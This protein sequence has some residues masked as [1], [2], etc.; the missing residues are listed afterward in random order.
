M[1]SEVAGLRK[2]LIN[3]GFFEN[4]DTEDLQR[5][6]QVLRDVGA[7]LQLD[8]KDVDDHGNPELCLH[9]IRGCSE[10][11]FDVQM[12][13]DPFEEKFDA[14]SLT[15][16]HGDGGGI[17]RE[18]VGQECESLSVPGVS[19]GHPPDAVGIESSRLWPAKAD[20]PVC[21]HAAFRH[22]YLSLEDTVIHV[23]LGP[24]NE[25]SRCSV[26]SMQPGEIDVAAVE[27]IEGARLRR[28]LIK[29]PQI[30]R[31]GVRNTHEYG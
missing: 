12:L 18:V 17:E 8:N 25:K 26:E 21:P 29:Q 6:I 11:C 27:Y 15:I 31:P 7:V 14:P 30:V 9:G 16:K 23:A 22:D 24:S 5:F 28:N 13:F 1:Y 10:E 2:Q 20:Q 3:R 19:I 4:C